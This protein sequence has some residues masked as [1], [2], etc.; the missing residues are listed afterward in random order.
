VKG[1]H[2]VYTHHNQAATLPF[3]SVFWIFADQQKFKNS[4]ETKMGFNYSQEKLRFDAE[5]R[6][7]AEEYR[8]AGFD[9]AGIHAMHEYDMEQFRKRRTYENH[10]QELPSEKFDEAD[11][12]SCSTL[13][14]KFNSLS[15]EFDESAFTGRYDWIDAI[16]DPVLAGKLA[17]LNDTDKELLTLLAFDGYKQAEVA[18]M[19]GCGHSVISR[20]L[21][22]IKKLI[23]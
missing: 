9:E 11:D 19:Q 23:S 18:V 4:E 17:A 10:T 1:A 6:K 15:T 16:D 12:D 14:Q 13:F 2:F 8:A 5:W 3:P 20:K 21:T 22:R 7:L